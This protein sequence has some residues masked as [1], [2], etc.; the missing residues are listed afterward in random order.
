MQPPNRLARVLGYFS[1]AYGYAFRKD[2]QTRR[3]SY[4][5]L[6]D[7]SAVAKYKDYSD[8]VDTAE[9]VRLAITSAWV[10]SGI[11]IIADRV[12]SAES[13]F[14]V[15]RRV[16]E[17][18]RDVRSHPFEVLLENPNS[19]MTIEYILRYTT[20]WAFL[21]G[22][23]YIF[24]STVAPGVGQPEELWPLPAN[25]ITPLPTSLRMSR[26]TGKPCIDYKYK[27]DDEHV[28][29]LPGENVVHIRFANIFDFWQ[30]LSPLTAMMDALKLDR[31]QM[32]Y[33]QGFF[34]RDNAVP[35]AIISVPQETNDID[36]EVIK[37]Q[38]REQFGEGRRSAITRAGDLDVKTITQTIQDM[39]VMN[40]RKLTRE[41]INHVIGIP[42]GLITGGSSGDS[43]LATDIAFTRNTVQP[44][45][46][47]IASEF[48]SA[49]GQYYGKNIVIAAPYIVPQDR[50]LKV[51][52]YAQYSQDR[53][54]NE[55]R[56]E[57]GLK[58]L[59]MVSVM[60]QVNTIRVGAGLEEINTPLDDAT[61][62]LL[63][64]MPVRLLPM[65]SSN[66]FSNA[67]KTGLRPGQIDASGEPVVD[68]M[69][70]YQQLLAGSQGED[71]SDGG[72]SN[73][74]SLANQEV[75]PSVPDLP[76][77][78][79][80]QNEQQKQ[81]GRSINLAGY[82]WEA[83]KVGQREELQRWKKIAVKL[84]RDGKNPAERAFESPALPSTLMSA[85]SGRLDGADETKCAIIFDTI[86]E[87]IHTA[88]MG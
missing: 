67:A 44:F 17:E 85:I 10:Y 32:R 47:M 63:L 29:I 35:T 7:M 3:Q 23:A 43:R 70:Q 69:E 71:G 55:N 28:Q 56:R 9:A 75:P 57:L 48:S 78:Q 83:F 82:R 5:I 37:Q 80:P 38:I 1:N 18:L 61:M 72:E 45:L 31:Y 21:T 73:A 11:K 54:I 41:E 42:D 62:D 12:A 4:A 74:P 58:P 16:G 2:D 22:N 88:E 30:G 84:A 40:A 25:R 49:I 64:N 81:S 77:M 87:T 53:S 6:S 8:T 15:K 36:F 60:V 34:G 46:D 66:T 59:D 76:G 33:L 13:R 65:V 86:I 39:E 14:Q 79:G 20:F 50:A 52:E 51:Q 24:V 68:P 27:I 26:L 19:M